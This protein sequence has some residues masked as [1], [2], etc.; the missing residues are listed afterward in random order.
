MPNR[1]RFVILLAATLLP[2]LPAQDARHEP[3]GA[4]LPSLIPIHTNDHAP[5]GSREY[6]WW[7]AGPNF[8]ASFQDGFAFYPV[9]PAAQTTRGWHWRTESIAVG[10]EPLP[11]ATPRLVPTDWRC[12]YRMGQI[13]EAYDVREAGVE[14]SFVI[15]HLPARGEIVVTGLVT[16]PFVAAAQPPTVGSIQFHEAD[17]SPV[18][19]YGKASV[20]DAAGNRQDVRTS[21]DGRRIRLHVD[22]AFVATAVLPI[23]ID[24]LTSARFVVQNLSQTCTHTAITAGSAPGNK[25]LL[26]A[27][28]RR[29]SAT[30]HDVVAYRFEEN[31]TTYFTTLADFAA[32]NDAAKV[33]VAEVDGSQTFVYAV[34]RNFSGSPSITT[35][36]VQS[37]TTGT[38][39]SGTAASLPPGRIDPQIGGCHDAGTKALVVS[40]EL[41]ASG[42]RRVRGAVLDT[43]PFALG[44]SFD[45]H[46][47]G[48]S[49]DSFDPAVNETAAG[50]E[51]W[52]VLWASAYG[53]ANDEIRACRVSQ[54]GVVTTTR[55]LVLA[56]AAREPRV[57]GSAGRYLATWLDTPAGAVAQL[58][59]ERFDLPATT[60]LSIAQHTMA[61]AALVGESI[62]N[63]DIAYDHTTTSHWASTYR[64]SLSLLGTPSTT[65][66]V[67]RHGFTGAVTEAQSLHATTGAGIANPSVCF[68]GRPLSGE[69]EGFGVAYSLLT[70]PVFSYPVYYRQFT[71]PTIPGGQ[72]GTSCR[73]NAYFD[74]HPPYAGSEFFRT[75]VHGLVPG[76]LSIALLGFQGTNQPLAAQGMP[77]C[78]LLVDYVATPVGFADI[79]GNASHTLALPDAPLFVG[80]IY[81]QWLWN[82]PAAN[83]AG[84]VT[85]QGIWFGVR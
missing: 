64:R 78:N 81:V 1:R 73:P 25:R 48:S 24:P 57:A 37:Q 10:G 9:I 7:T 46:S 51:P 5:G 20:V 21:Y 79:R 69:A 72:H 29:Q 82:E 15:D 18:L 56:P 83:A 59:S 60:I 67:L 70:D 68:D 80:D 43:Q 65:A 22:A 49:A 71:Y 30:D 44:A 23:T 77:G 2:I 14:Q 58:H 35:T 41:L 11:T 84:F 28:V 76:T 62:T 31:T 6:G 85:G 63:G 50:A 3:P 55:T 34:Q 4:P 13:T 36:L 19:D 66:W 40:T 45:L 27:V 38:L 12:E 42:S 75:G 47:F 74:G 54:L 26:V 52:M 16:T 61:T 33:D 53:A 17:G 8:K 32:T 39:N